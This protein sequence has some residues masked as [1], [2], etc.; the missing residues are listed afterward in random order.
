MKCQQTIKH[1]LLLV[2]LSYS[3]AFQSNNGRRNLSFVYLSVSRSVAA[4]SPDVVTRDITKV[5][6]KSYT[7]TID[8]SNA[9]IQFGQ[10]GN[11]K[12]VNRFGMW[13]AVVSLLTGPV[14]MM[15]MSM[16]SLVYKCNSNIDPHRSIYDATGKIWAKVWL[17]M[18][19]CYPTFSGNLGHVKSFRGPCLY[20]A[21]HASWMDIPVLCTVLD[22]VFKFI[23]KGELQEV[24]CIGQQLVGGNHILIDR[25]DKRSQL[26]SFKEGINWLNKGVPVMAFP[27]GMR[28]IDGRLKEFK[29]GI[30]SLSVK[31]KV[32]II[33]ITISHT[34]AVMPAFSL[35][36]I[37]KG[38]GKIHVHVNDPIY[39]EGKT[40][41]ELETVVWDTFIRTLPASQLPRII[42]SE[43]HN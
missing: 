9:L 18:S 13:C 27:E 35:F 25:E 6:E 21:N 29:K 32:P 2:T 11:V 34:H 8:E 14:W 7:K 41:R 43:S 4:T 26:R 19:D 36:P 37:Q 24:P 3:H 23:A 31:T 5:D 20:V 30:F 40:E 33:P 17:H 1:F 42:T 39:P 15:A 38:A 22:P 28:S 12:I 10:E 16:L